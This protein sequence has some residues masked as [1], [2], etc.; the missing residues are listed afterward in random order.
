MNVVKS[1]SRNQKIIYYSLIAIATIQIIVIATLVYLKASN[2]D[3]PLN[4]ED[5]TNA[6]NVEDEVNL[7]TCSEGIQLILEEEQALERID[8]TLIYQ[9]GGYYHDQFKIDFTNNE[10]SFG[11]QIINYAVSF[12]FVYD[13]LNDNGTRKQNNIDN[14]NKLRSEFADTPIM[15][16]YLGNDKQ[17]WIY[18]ENKIIK[19]T[20]SEDSTIDD[21]LAPYLD[22]I[23]AKLSAIGCSLKNQDV[24]IL[25]TYQTKKVSSMDY[26]KDNGV[27]SDPIEV[28]KSTG[29]DS[30]VDKH[31]KYQGLT[32]WRDYTSVEHFNSVNG[33][34][35]N[36]GKMIVVYDIDRQLN[37]DFN[38][39]PQY[40][41]LYDPATY[42]K[43]YLADANQINPL[44]MT[45]FFRDIYLDYALDSSPLVYFVNRNDPSGANLKFSSDTRCS[46]NMITIEDWEC[47]S[48]NV[49]FEFI[50]DGNEV[51]YKGFA[52]ED[53][54][55]Q[56]YHLVKWLE[57]YIDKSKFSEDFFIEYTRVYDIEWQRQYGLREAYWDKYGF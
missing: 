18:T 55:S 41:H 39:D 49:L 2:D 21:E 57:H 28:I 9:R 15:A 40:W 36:V 37:R 42:Y 17:Y 25:N 12:D 4:L 20:S 48:D 53:D 19:R 33:V 31:P 32:D 11:D 45:N 23:H 5:V 38:V 7:I 47:T 14:L 30:L 3:V 44:F 51:K 1:F 29:I 52:W 13:Y 8:G 43:Y 54:K 16:K 35:T 6:P 50:T 46:T 27:I 26:W 10:M 22:G 34:K 24:S 56:I